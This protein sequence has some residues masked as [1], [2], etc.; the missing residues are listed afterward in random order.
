PLCL[1]SEFFKK[2]AS[3]ILALLKDKLFFSTLKKEVVKSIWSNKC[4]CLLW[5]VEPR[6]K[7]LSAS[8][9]FCNLC[10][11]TKRFTLLLVGLSLKSPKTII[12]AALSLVI[13]EVRISLTLCDAA[14]R[15]CSVSLSF[16]RLEGQ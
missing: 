14:K 3:K 8:K 7:D 13:M 4:H 15:L 1:P 12:L 16:S 9:G 2:A 10:S 11:F 6:L 5:M